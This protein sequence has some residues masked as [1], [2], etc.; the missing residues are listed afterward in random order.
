MIKVLHDSLRQKAVV[1]EAKCSLSTSANEGNETRVCDGMAADSNLPTKELLFQIDWLFEFLVPGFMKTRLSPFLDITNDDVIFEDKI[2]NYNFVGKQ[3]LTM[4]I[5]KVRAYYRYLS[6]YNK[7]ED[8]M[9]VIEGAMDVHI[10]KEGRIY[11]IVNRKITA[12]DL[13]GAK[14]MAEMKKE[15]DEEKAKAERRKWARQF[16]EVPLMFRQ[17]LDYTFYRNDVICDDRIFNVKRQGL[18]QYMSHLGAISV[19]C[20]LLFPHI[21][22]EA[23]SIVP[24]LDDGTVRL[25]WRVKHVSLLRALTNPMLF[26]Y[27]YRVK[28]VM[29]D[30]ER[31][32]DSKSATQRLAE[33]MGV[34]PKGAQAASLSSPRSQI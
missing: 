30:E 6:P 31:G 29:P 17:R 18:Q 8:K 19:T 24:I 23:L 9:D 5:A 32:V 12:S 1:D 4:H 16:D 34:L 22:M 3:Q 11:K 33:K 20:Q 7:V 15:V 27:D 26:K 21:E 2:F 25:R 10:S 13:E 14:V 28:R